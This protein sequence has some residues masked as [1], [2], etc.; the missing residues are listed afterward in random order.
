MGLFGRKTEIEK[1]LAAA[2]NELATTQHRLNA[3]AAK[4][5]E[6]L[7]DGAAYS[8]WRAERDAAASEVDRLTRLIAALEAGE[9]TARQHDFDEALRKRIDAA[10]KNNAAVAERLRT[11]GAQLSTALKALVREVALS[12]IETAAINRILPAGVAALADANNLARGRPSVPR[13]DIEEKTLS[14]W[15]R[16]T[17]GSLLGDQ[18]AIVAVDATTGHLFVNNSRVDCVRREFRSVQYHPPG[19]SEI[20]EPFHALLRIPNFD[21]LGVDFDGQ[22]MIE[23]HVAE[24]NLDAPKAEKKTRRP[25]QTE[26]IPVEPWTPTVM[27]AVGSL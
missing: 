22:L 12:Q 16:S 11:E 24:L 27:K 10:K 5:T 23:E 15:V 7:A 2:R 13:K 9:E 3:T 19:W 17:D 18:D 25:V 20:P 8:T 6:A 26:L 21:R 1:R 14:L 4:E